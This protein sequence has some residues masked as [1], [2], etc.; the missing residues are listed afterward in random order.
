M[1]RAP[2]HELVQ[3]IRKSGGFVNA[4]SHLDRAWTVGSDDLAT[5]V[6]APLQEKWKLIDDVK[7]ASTEEDYYNRMHHALS[8][9]REMGTTAC[10]SFVDCDA[11]AEERALNA[12][13]RLRSQSEKNMGITLRLA[14]QTLKGVCNAHAR[15]WFDKAV[16]HVDIIGGLPGA[17]AGREGE[18]LDIILSTAKALNKRVH[19]H[20]DQN[21]SPDERE[22]E[23]LARKS[24]QW[25]MEGRVSAVHGISLAAHNKNYRFEVYKLC[26]DAGL[27]FVACPTAWIDARRNETLTPTHN[28]ITPIDELAEQGIPVAIG[29]DNI[30][31]LY[32]P[33]AD[34]NMEVE[35]RVLLESTHF[36][37]MEELVRIATVHGRQVM[38]I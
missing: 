23:L 29:S 32:K 38:G 19:V 15:E 14:V 5:R 30:A 8:I 31:D 16:P 28:A 27:S 9:Q 10:L 11:V 35:L 22:T 2:L 20:V 33:F 3:R 25:G 34:G 24:I 21:N 7:R 6:Y 17:D 13:L 37:D 36:Y 18:H 12:A 1:W 4:H 26:R